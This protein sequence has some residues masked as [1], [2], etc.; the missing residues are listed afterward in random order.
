VEGYPLLVTDSR[1][2]HISLAVNLGSTMR[3]LLNTISS[4]DG[5]W[6]G[7]CAAAERV[8]GKAAR[9]KSGLHRNEFLAVFEPIMRTSQTFSSPP[10]RSSPSFENGIAA[11]S[12]DLAPYIRAIV[13]FD[14]RLERYRLEL[15]GLSSRGSS[16]AG[17]MRRTRASRAALEGNDKAHTRR[18]RWFPS[19]VNSSWILATGGK[20]W[21]DTLVQSGHFNV[22]PII[23]E[24]RRS[25]PS[26]S[27]SSGDGGF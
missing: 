18:E 11:I 5:G 3:V 2:D 17:R 6:G 25:N 14:L 16:F 26:L 21:Q 22:R 1:Q 8:L 23:R 19:D 4:G 10:G 9:Q 20:D 12:E 27:E 24:R 13:A 7:E 15:S